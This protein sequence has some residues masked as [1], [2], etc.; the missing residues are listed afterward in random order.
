MRKTILNIALLFVLAIVYWFSKLWVVPVFD[1]ASDIY[2][3][4]AITIIFA[5]IILQLS[6]D[7]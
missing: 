4:S 3:A 5:L 7:L 2:E 1:I 6:P